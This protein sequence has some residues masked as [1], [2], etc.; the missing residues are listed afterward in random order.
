[1]DLTKLKRTDRFKIGPSVLPM[2]FARKDF[3]NGVLVADLPQTPYPQA[4]LHS[5]LMESKWSLSHKKPY[6]ISG[7]GPFA[8]KRLHYSSGLVSTFSTLDWY[9]NPTYLERYMGNSYNGLDLNLPGNS[10]VGPYHTYDSFRAAFESFDFPATPLEPFGATAISRFNP[11]KPSVNLAQDIGELLHDGIPALIGSAFKKSQS[12][13]SLGS[14][15]LNVEFGWRPLLKSLR[16]LYNLQT[17]IDSRIRQIIRDNGKPVR[18]KGVLSSDTSSNIE[19]HPIQ[20][21]TLSMY[22]TGLSQFW[23]DQTADRT[24]HD[25]TRIWFAGAFRYYL[26]DRILKEGDKSSEL[27]KALFGSNV[28]PATVYQLV[29]WSWLIDWFSNVGDVLNNF[30]NVQPGDPTLDY[31][32]VMRH[33]EIRDEWRCSLPSYTTYP[34]TEAQLRPKQQVIT[35]VMETKERVAATPYGFGIE[36]SSLSARQFAILT[37]LGLTRQ[38]FL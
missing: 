16:D 30:F 3:D 12:L 37:A 20:G 29:P 1:M 25:T 34:G 7:G 21:F 33:R 11:L 19:R 32:F 35:T 26:P 9:L 27:R 13:K 17:T 15:Y 28:T 31:G 36:L 8:V 4:L 14:E 2:G 5:A 6:T 23:P 24:T 22:N 38:N 10:P 18:R